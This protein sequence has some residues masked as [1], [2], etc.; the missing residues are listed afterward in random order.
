MS[1]EL[2]AKLERAATNKDCGSFSSFAGPR[3][4][5][6]PYIFSI[7]SDSKTDSKTGGQQWISVDGGGHAIGLWRGWKTLVDGGRRGVPKGGLG[8]R[9]VAVVLFDQNF[10]PSILLI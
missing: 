1:D 3:K 4:Q 8:T 6:P 7:T 2:H 5:L 10:R 9:N